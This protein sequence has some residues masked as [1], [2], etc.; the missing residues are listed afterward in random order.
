MFAIAIG[1]VCIALALALGFV[2]WI[3]ALHL[4]KYRTDIHPYY[5]SPGHGE[6]ISIEWN[7]I[8]LKNYESEAHKYVYR[9]HA[10]LVLQ[11][12]LLLLGTVISFLAM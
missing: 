5:D 7:L 12:V 1:A 4:Q 9:L 3:M 2:A 6:S 8:R 10:V 11:V